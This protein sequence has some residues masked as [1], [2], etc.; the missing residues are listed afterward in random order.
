MFKI[1]PCNRNKEPLI[2]EWQNLA[3]TDATQIDTWK[4]QYNGTLGSWGV[5]TGPINGIL[6]LDVDVK[7]HNGFESLKGLQL[8]Q[9]M[10]QRSRSGGMH[11]IFRYPQDGKRYGN[12]VNFKPGLDI[13]GVGGY[14][15]W[16]GADLKQ[17]IADPPHWLLDEALKQDA[18]ATGPVIRLAPEIAQSILNEVLDAIREAPPGES[19][20]TLNA[21]SYRAG[22]LVASQCYTRESVEQALL[23]AALARGKPMR[24]ARATIKSGLNGGIA[25]PMCSPFA[26]PVP[27]IEIPTPASLVQRWTPTELTRYDLTNISKLRK[28]QIF[29]HWSSE[30]IAITTAD[31][32]TGKTTLKLYEAICLA[33]GERFMGFDCKQAGKTLFITG[34]D[35]DKKLAA[36]MG[37]MIRQM[38]LFEEQVGNEEKIQ[39]ILQSIRIKKDSDLC[40]IVRD[41]QGFLS[42]NSDAMRKIIEAVDDVKPKLIVF[43]PIASFW[44]S[45]A[46]LN[47]MAKAVAKFTGELVEY[48]GA[49]V[50]MLNH[51]GKQSSAA[52]DM[53]QFA[54]RG[55]TGLPSHARISRVLRPVGEEEYEKAVGQ[56]LGERQS[57]IMCNVNKYSDGSPLYNKQFLIVREGYLFRRQMLS[58]VKVRELEQEASD[59][60]RIFTF[61]KR[62][63]E[64]DRYPTPNVVIGHFMSQSDNLSEA[65]I[66]RA[67]N[68]LQY[69]GHLGDKVKL[70]ENPDMSISEKA[71]VVIDNQG[72]EL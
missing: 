58:D 51:M 24:E 12:R 30:D 49:C 43:D 7:K 15:C 54:G 47:D 3:T 34:E 46:A 61:I 60:E 10:M 59:T 31:G 19:N 2:P 55:G 40:L 29:D 42:P 1:F 17:P 69:T 35:S 8:P 37:A 32:G 22:Q 38:G 62:E 33:L 6:V 57:A 50:E 71:F 11:L 45:E 36:V 27:V 9:T 14:I 70:V 26:V 68:L 41:R 20:D 63:R 23:A 66:K 4:Q 72:K 13:R 48:S 25:H 52:K 39:T 28:P 65:R 64:A 18:P 5:A 53:T 44:G 56:Q 21:Q 16:Y 67:I